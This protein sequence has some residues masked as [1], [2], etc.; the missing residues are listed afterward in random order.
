MF[1]SLFI[2]ALRYELAA[3]DRSTIDADFAGMVNDADYQAEAR[4]IAKEFVNSDWESLHTVDKP[5]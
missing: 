1:K 3:L 2:Q 5:S 4:Q